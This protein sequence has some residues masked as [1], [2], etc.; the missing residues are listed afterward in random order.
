DTEYKEYQDDTAESEKVAQQ[1]RMQS[2][3]DYGKKLDFKPKSN[4]SREKFYFRGKEIPWFT[5]TV[6]KPEDIENFRKNT[7]AELSSTKS[8]I[9]KVPG[10]NPELDQKKIEKNSGPGS[11]LANNKEKHQQ[12]SGSGS[13]LAL[14][15][16]N[17]TTKKNPKTKR[18]DS[19]EVHENKENHKKIKADDLEVS[20]LKMK[21]ME[22][23]DVIPYKNFDKEL[24][25]Q[26]EIFIKE[27]KKLLNKIENGSPSVTTKTKKNEKI[28]KD[29]D[30]NETKNTIKN[31]K[32]TFANITKKNIKIQQPKALK[33]LPEFSNEQKKIIAAGMSPFEATKYKLIYFDGF[34]RNRISLVKNMLYE[35]IQPRL[36]GNTNWTADEK[37]EVCVESNQIEK[38]VGYMEKIDCVKLNMK[39]DPI[40]TE[41]SKNELSER[42][43]WLSSESNR[44]Q[45]SRRMARMVRKW[46]FDDRDEFFEFFLLSQ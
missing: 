29:N 19:N 41:T 11:T 33:K 18:R 8:K 28:K 38:L 9:S 42:L 36:I 20:A 27:S 35:E 45:P 26:V 13:T 46:K 12:K 5:A 16:D 14:D 37:L 4:E 6:S 40:S 31:T 25:A 43:K 3:K 1:L 7:L 15:D 23:S 44:N 22:I 2:L 34:K 21:I 17:P 30:N 24:I 39:Y 10:S 32:T